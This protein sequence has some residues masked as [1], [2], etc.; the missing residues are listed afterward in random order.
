[1]KPA[2]RRALGIAG[3]VV[4]VLAAFQVLRADV[5]PGRLHFWWNLGFGLVVVLVALV[6]GLR[7]ADLGLER[8]HVGSGLRWG[9][10]CWG[11]AVIGFGIVGLA[12]WTRG[13]YH[14]HRA[15]V[16]TGALLWKVL[17]AIPLATALMEELVFRGVIFGA[18]AR[19]TTATRAAI[20]SALAFGFWHVQPTLGSLGANAA[21]DG[22]R[23]IAQVG[24]V[25]GV[26]V[27]MT[28]AGLF[29]A[30]LRIR[31]RSLVAPFLTHWGVNATAL[32][33]AWLVARG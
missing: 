26:V 15:T 29:L 21:T 23:G 5:V 27:A 24:L 10:A 11:L 6:A 32:V 4:V 1:M 3:A 17:V 25:A 9:L 33:V 16:S 19:I 14:D 18:T 20:V 30:W 13:V 8:R 7:T 22:A 28:A 2:R 12:P 31:S